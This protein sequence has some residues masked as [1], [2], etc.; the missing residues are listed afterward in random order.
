MLV[1][2]LEVP[3]EAHIY[4]LPEDATEL[5]KLREIAAAGVHCGGYYKDDPEKKGLSWDL[6]K[7][8]YSGME[9]EDGSKTDEAP[10]E[11]YRSD[12]SKTSVFTTQTSGDLSEV[13]TLGYLF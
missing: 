6:A 1:V 11:K 3:E 12:G 10:M 9:D 5:P 4:I 2:L 7:L 8:F 13:I